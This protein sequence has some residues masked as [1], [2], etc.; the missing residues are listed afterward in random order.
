MYEE[1]DE[2]YEVPTWAQV[3]TV[4]VRLGFGCLGIGLA[5]LGLGGF[6]EDCKKKNEGN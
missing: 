2:N 5:C 3:A 1:V 6:Y 4:F